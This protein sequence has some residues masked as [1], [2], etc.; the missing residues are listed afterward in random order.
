VEPAASRLF[1]IGNYP[2]EN[3]IKPPQIYNNLL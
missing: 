3:T 1:A 2:V